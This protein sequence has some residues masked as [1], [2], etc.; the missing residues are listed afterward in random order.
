MKQWLETIKPDCEIFHTTEINFETA[1]DE[2]IFS[3]AQEKKALIITFDED[4]TDIRIFKQP[5]YGVVRLNMWPI[6]V[7]E[8]KKVFERLF[9]EIK[10]DEINNSLI[11]IDRNKIRIRKDWV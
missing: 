6:T 1:T 4:F 10:D 5:H 11:I 3:I 9:K 7:E 2:D 8:I